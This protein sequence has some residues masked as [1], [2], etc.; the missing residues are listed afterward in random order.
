MKEEL[1]LVSK[2]VGQKQWCLVI[3]PFWQEPYCEF[4]AS[5]MLENFPVEY[6]EYV[7]SGAVYRVIRKAV[8]SAYIEE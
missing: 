7:N 3:N 6:V 4:Y 1:V 8:L 2:M 5:K